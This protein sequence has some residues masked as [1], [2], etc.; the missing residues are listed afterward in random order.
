MYVYEYVTV[1]TGAGAFGFPAPDVERDP[2]AVIDRRAAEGW[3]YVGCLPKDF[4]VR[5]EPGALDLVFEREVGQ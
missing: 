1:S 2:R 3:R 5:G 4:G